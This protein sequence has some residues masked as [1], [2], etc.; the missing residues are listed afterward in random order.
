VK[1]EKLLFICGKINP[2]SSQGVRYKNLIPGIQKD[3][4]VILLSF[5]PFEIENSIIKYILFEKENLSLGKSLS[6]RTKILKFTKS[7]F[8]KKIHPL[9][10]PDKYKFFLSK[11]QFK[12]DEIFSKE[13]ISKVIIG[14][15]PFSLLSLVP[16][17]KNKYPEVELI[18]DLSDPFT[19]NAANEYSFFQ[20]KKK[21]YLFEKRIIEKLDKLVVLNPQ[22]QKLYK[23]EFSIDNVYVIEQGL[24]PLDSN[25]GLGY[26][27]KHPISTLIYAGGLYKNFREAFELYK[28]VD[29]FKGEIKLEIFGN[30]KS[31]LL[32][33]S[34]NCSH[35]GIIDSNFLINEYKRFDGIVFIDNNSGYQVPGKILEIQE[36]GKPILFIYSNPDSPTFDYVFNKNIIMVKNEMTSIIE[37][38]TKN[39]ILNMFSDKSAKLEEF[40]WDNLVKKYNELLDD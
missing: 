18:V 36:I 13:K 30:I 7:Q 35:K 38:L 24:K 6:I 28:A 8:N 16:Y 29:S 10:F 26:S 19:F 32:P 23:S 12:I 9:I 2:Y 14:V 37:G 25:I 11:Y 4:E 31:E 1:K 39:K 20:S 22:I 33:H 15:T 3:Y 27:L 5:T 34:V 17:I 21:I 40:Y